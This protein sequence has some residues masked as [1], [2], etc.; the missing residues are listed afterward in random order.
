LDSKIELIFLPPYAPNLNL[1]ERYWRF[2]KKEIL[3]GKYYE[4]FAL[5]RQ[6]CDTFF[7]APECYKE[8]LRSLLT[9]N[10]QI[11]DSAKAPISEVW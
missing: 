5:L 2:F 11:I 4:T 8:A 1:I 3:Y 9:D 7:A 6:A 10:F